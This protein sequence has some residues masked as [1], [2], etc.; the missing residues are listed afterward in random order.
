MAKRRDPIPVHFRCPEDET[1]FFRYEIDGSWG[2]VPRVGEQVFLPE[3]QSNGGWKEC[4]IVGVETVIT[5]NYVDETYP[6]TNCYMLY[7]Q[8]HL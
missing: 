8:H 1:L 5:R 7:K 2:F 4:E 6:A 3:K